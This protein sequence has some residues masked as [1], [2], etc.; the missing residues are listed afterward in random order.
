MS[1]RDAE[2]DG[3]D[4]RTE[5]PS[6]APGDGLGGTSLDEAPEEAVST[7]AEEE[8][9]EQAVTPPQETAATS[10][11]EWTTPTSWQSALAGV[12]E[13]DSSPEAGNDLAEARAEDLAEVPAGP[14]EGVP[15]SGYG[16]PASMPETSP[17]GNAR[18]AAAAASVP[19][20]TGVPPRSPFE[21]A[22]SPAADQAA[23][24]SATAAV[25]AVTGGVRGMAS[26]VGSSFSGLGNRLTDRTKPR[27]PQ[28]GPGTG[29]PAPVGYPPRGGV[30]QTARQPAATRAQPRRAQ[31]TLMRFEPWSVMKFSFLISL[32]CWVVLFVVV[33]LLYFTLSKL[34]VF[35]AIETNWRLVTSSKTN[36]AGS[37]I[38]QWFSASR[39]LGYTM[40][41]GAVNVVLITALATIGSVL[42]NLITALTGGIEVTLKESD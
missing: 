26:R 11:P 3:V 40:L 17:N 28:A 2:E 22:G 38:A 33:T 6:R 31:L 20:A 39:V 35:H 36:P 10:E 41:I 34:G 19:S 25:A 9:A 16:S 24:L 23:Q 37:R 12:V 30:S 5:V 7:A 29:Q 32:V 4:N 14:D 27:Y 42:Y 8:P 21:P 1:V 18:E 13:P 15:G